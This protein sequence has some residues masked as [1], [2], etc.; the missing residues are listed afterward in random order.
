MPKTLKPLAGE[1]KSNESDRAVQ[2]LND[3]LRM[4]PGRSLSKLLQRYAKSRKT[5]QPTDSLN[6]LRKWHELFEWQSRSSEYD[7]ASER[8][9][10]ARRQKVFDTGLAQDHARVTELKKLAGFLKGEIYETNTVV[11]DDDEEEDAPVVEPIFKNPKVWLK[12]IKIVGSGEDAY[13][14]TIYRFNSQ[15]I[16]QYRGVLDD[17]AKEVGDR[18]QK[19]EHKVEQI[20]YSRLSDDQ[21]ERIASGE[22]PYKVVLS[23]YIAGRESEG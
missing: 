10:N 23:G 16:D 4:G 12:D 13:P 15:L 2:A 9:K 1:R 8:D 5:T 7:A 6:T 20:E 3:Y 22:D 19:L 14:V 21:L 18:R 11:A 17:L